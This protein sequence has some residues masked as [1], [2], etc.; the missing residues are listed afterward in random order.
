MTVLIN[1][2]SNAVGCGLVA[3]NLGEIRRYN[4]ACNYAYTNV[5]G[6]R[7]YEECAKAGIECAKELTKSIHRY[8]LK[9]NDFKAI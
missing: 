5:I 2:K 8:V 3:Y 7:V 4:L 6:E 1:E 9:Y